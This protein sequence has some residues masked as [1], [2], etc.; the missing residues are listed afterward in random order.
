MVVSI[1]RVA[2]G[3]IHASLYSRWG[4]RDAAWDSDLIILMSRKNAPR[5]PPIEMAH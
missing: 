5:P 1:A 2:A 3:W 4:R